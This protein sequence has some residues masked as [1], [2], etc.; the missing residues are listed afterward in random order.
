VIDTVNATTGES[1]RRRRA[2]VLAICWLS[3]LLVGPVV[4]ALVVGTH[5]REPA[6]E[7][8]HQV[9]QERRIPWRAVGSA[10]LSSVLVAAPLVIAAI[11]GHPAAGVALTLGAYLG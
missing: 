11:V 5:R 3:V 1:C 10:L 2:L 4:V 6:R 8:T 7:V 9:P